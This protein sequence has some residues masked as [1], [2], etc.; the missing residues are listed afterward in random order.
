M[1][2]R[3]DHGDAAVEQRQRPPDSALL[4]RQSAE[5][6]AR[7]SLAAQAAARAGGALSLMAVLL[8]SP[9]ARAGDRTRRVGRLSRSRRDEHRFVIGDGVLPLVNFA[10]SRPVL[11]TAADI[12]AWAEHAGQ[13]ED[14]L[15]LLDDLDQLWGPQGEL[16]RLAELAAGR[17]AEVSWDTALLLSMS[18]TGGLQVDVANHLVRRT[19][20]VLL[21]PTT[22]ARHA[23]A[24]DLVLRE[25]LDAGLRGGDGGH[26]RI[27]TLGG[28]GE[29]R[30]DCTPID[31]GHADRKAPWWARAALSGVGQAGRCSR[32]VAARLGVLQRQ[33]ATS[34]N[35]CTS[36]AFSPRS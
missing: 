12:E 3:R 29:A 36:W 20:E 22:S 35:S 14:G 4:D 26:R 28:S 33:L 21:L 1:P 25:L 10:V 8:V 17:R 31:C 18:A 32:P 30:A 19:G 13:L 34:R 23:L 11:G 6:R 2:G 15:A 7:R 27:R 24:A 5:R 9:G 16:D